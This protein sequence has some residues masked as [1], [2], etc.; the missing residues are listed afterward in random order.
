MSGKEDASSA[1]G[2]AVPDGTLSDKLAGLQLDRLASNAAAGNGL[3]ISLA[4]SDMHF[5]LC[6]SGT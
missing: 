2:H 4:L 3:V 6:M 5:I 1:R